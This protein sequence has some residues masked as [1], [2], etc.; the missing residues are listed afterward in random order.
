MFDLAP[1]S[2][3]FIFSLGVT[4]LLLVAGVR[5]LRFAFRDTAFARSLTI[6]A[7]VDYMRYPFR[8]V[9][10]ISGTRIA[11]FAI[12]TSDSEWIRYLH[13]A[14]N[15]AL[16]ASVVWFL[17]AIAFAVEYTLVER[18]EAATNPG[19][20]RVRRSITQVTL[21]RRLVV[22]LFV[23]IGIAAV[24]MTFSTFRTVGT[25]LLAS[26]GIIS[27]V[28]GIA[29]QA[30]LGNVFAGIH[31]AFSNTLRVDD[32]IVIDGESGTVDDITLTTV[33]VHLWNDRR[34]ILP[35]SHFMQNGF[36]NWTRSGARISGSVMLDLDWTAPLDDMRA[37][38]TRFLEASPLWDGR[39][40]SLKLADATGGTI[41][42]RIDI[43]AADTLKLF[44]LSSSVRE[45]MVTYLVQ[46]APYSL[47]QRR[48]QTHATQDIAVDS[49]VP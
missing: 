7:V 27:V 31:L 24:L 35:S 38:L 17:A 39:T 6:P 43:S 44:G 16:I 2:L 13:H 30:T 21:L 41:R 46:N 23:F 19:E 18:Y 36:E 49:P 48:V 29:A 42:I 28:V 11:L 33:I 47:P 10:F 32:V 4:I 12:N 34:L 1:R 22:V 45:A 37:E 9:V 14:L 15:I 20:V 26:A 3:L 8:S 5:V 40:G 25:T